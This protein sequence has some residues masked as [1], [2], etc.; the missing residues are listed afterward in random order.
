[1]WNKISKLQKLFT[2][3]FIHV[4]VHIFS[5]SRNPETQDITQQN[6]NIFAITIVGCSPHIYMYAAWSMLV[7]EFADHKKML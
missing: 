4:H 5:L 1:M 6:L 7:F 2:S 3:G